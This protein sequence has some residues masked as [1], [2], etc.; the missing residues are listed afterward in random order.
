MS[1]T[2]THGRRLPDWCTSTWLMLALP[3]LIALLDAAL[4]SKG[5]RWWEAALSVL[6]AV[7]LLLRRRL[8]VTV[9][10][11]TLPGAFVNY[12]WLAPMTAV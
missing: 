10:L 2:R 5:A 7:A 4:V 9:L 11:L 8:P 6:A 12:I 3:V 1:G